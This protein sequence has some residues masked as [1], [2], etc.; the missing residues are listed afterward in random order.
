MQFKFFISLWIGFTL[1]AVRTIDGI[2]LQNQLELIERAY[3]WEE[4][5]NAFNSGVRVNM[6][7]IPS[8]GDT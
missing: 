8:S 1:I 6:E 2:L 5:K 3:E 7:G 4:N